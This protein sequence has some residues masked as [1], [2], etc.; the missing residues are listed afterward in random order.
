MR[1]ILFATTVALL[2]PAGGGAAHAQLFY[3][4]LQLAAQCTLAYTGD[5]RSAAAVGMI[6]WACNDYYTRT[7]PLNNA[8]RRY[9]AC[10]VRH[11]SGAQ[12]GFAAAQI[13]AACRTVFPL[14]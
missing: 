9:D 6:Q 7:G 10:L 4:R 2:V 13:A 3:Q 1:P 8:N 5:T 12:S 11:L 14:F